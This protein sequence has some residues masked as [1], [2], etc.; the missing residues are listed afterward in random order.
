MYVGMQTKINPIVFQS[1]GTRTVV[2]PD[3]EARQEIVEAPV[4]TRHILVVSR[5]GRFDTALMEHTLNIAERLNLDLVCLYIDPLPQWSAENGPRRRF[6]DTAR[7]NAAFFEARARERRVRIDTIITDGKVVERVGEFVHAIRR[8]EFV[9]VEPGIRTEDLTAMLSVPVFSA[10]VNPD[11]DVRGQALQRTHMDIQRLDGPEPG[12]DFSSTHQL[13]GG[14]GEEMAKT[15]LRKKTVQ[16]TLIFGM[17]AAALYAVVF[18]FADQILAITTKGGFFALVSVATVFLFSYVHGHFTSYFWSALGI[19]ASKT[20]AVKPTARVQKPA[21]RT[22][23]RP[24]A[25]LNV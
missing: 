7:E 18:A 24:R 10:V 11:T 22:D 16:K 8:V 3:P 23:K 20:V 21:K 12:K 25:R 14:G 15:E 2:A 6:S 19:E 1:R 13:I 5:K 17:G 4:P 9:V